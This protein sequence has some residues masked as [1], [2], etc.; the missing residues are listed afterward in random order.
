MGQVKDPWWNNPTLHN[1][2]LVGRILFFG[3]FFLSR[4][5]EREKLEGKQVKLTGTA[6]PSSPGRR[7]TS[8]LFSR[9]N[10]P[11]LKSGLAM[12]MLTDS[13]LL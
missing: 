4:F 6:E 1:N 13:A 5:K 8:C 2:F 7:D 10:S 3:G 11:S 9:G 12:C